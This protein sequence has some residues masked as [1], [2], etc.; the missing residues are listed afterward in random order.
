MRPLWRRP[1]YRD[2]RRCIACHEGQH[3]LWSRE[4]PARTKEILR[5]KAARRALS[6]L[7]PISAIPPTL[8]EAYGAQAES[9]RD[10][11]WSTVTTKKRKLA[12]RPLGAVSKARTISRDAGQ[13]VFSFISRPQSMRGASEAPAI[14]Q[15]TQPTE[16][17]QMDCDVIQA[18]REA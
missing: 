8:R 9:M 7:F 1:Q 12:G 2:M 13:S 6:R 4:C 5:A 15:P 3:I 11:G 17:S 16:H 14:I 18:E 10:E